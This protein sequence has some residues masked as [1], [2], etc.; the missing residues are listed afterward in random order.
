MMGVFYYGRWYNRQKME[1]MLAQEEMAC[2][3][4]E[5]AYQAALE[6]YQEM[7]WEELRA[8]FMEY[9]QAKEI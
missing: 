5:E 9:I 8:I 4:S 1:H 7:P 6:S 2:V 3:Y